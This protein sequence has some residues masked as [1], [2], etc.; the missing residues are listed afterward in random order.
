MLLVLMEGVNYH[1]ATIILLILLINPLLVGN[2]IHNESHNPPISPK[3]KWEW[4]VFR[5]GLCLKPFDFLYISL[6]RWTQQNVIYKKSRYLTKDWFQ[7]TC[8]AVSHSNHYTRIF[9]EVLVRGCNWSL[10]KHGWFCQI[11]LVHLIRRK[12]LHLEQTCLH[13]THK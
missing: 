6:I 4:L 11:Y 2:Y 10:F 7:I 1:F 12:C 5:H 9:L 13:L 3:I 8:L